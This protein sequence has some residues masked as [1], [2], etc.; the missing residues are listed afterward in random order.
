MLQSTSDPTSYLGT[1]QGVCFCRK[2]PLFLSPCKLPRV[3]NQYPKKRLAETS[4]ALIQLHPYS[5]E[6]AEF[7]GS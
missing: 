3:L 2:H 4:A 1:E 6:K 7:A 5:A